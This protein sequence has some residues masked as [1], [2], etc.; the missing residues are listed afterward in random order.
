MI[1]LLPHQL[2]RAHDDDDDDGQ[3]TQMNDESI[4]AL[5]VHLMN[6]MKTH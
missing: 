2:Q 6:E 4:L 5:L 3:M 1:D